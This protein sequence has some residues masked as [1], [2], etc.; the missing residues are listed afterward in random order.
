MNAITDTK[1]NRNIKIPRKLDE[2][3]PNLI[4]NRK[5]II[6]GKKCGTIPVNLP[7]K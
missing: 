2:C 5:Q 4:N 6:A 1:I 3:Q 7:R